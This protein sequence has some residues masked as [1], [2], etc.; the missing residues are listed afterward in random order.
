MKRMFR[1]NRRRLLG[2]LLAGACVVG[3]VLVS[4]AHTA[5]E[6]PGEHPLA[7]KYVPVFPAQRTMVKWEGKE[8]D[9]DSGIDVIMDAAHGPEKSDDQ[10]A[11]ALME[12]SQLRADLKGRPCLDVLAAR[13]DDASDLE[14]KVIL[15]CFTASGDPRGIP[16]FTNVLN[17]E[18]DLKLRVRAASGLASWNVRRGVAELVGLLDSDE[19]MPQ[20]SQLFYV[21][22]NAMRAFRLKNIRK[23]WGFP[24]DQES[25]EWPPDVAPPPDVAERLRPRPTV[26][27]IRKWWAENQHRFPD[28]KVGDPLP[29][30]SAEDATPE[31]NGDE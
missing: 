20:P 31:P 6:P 27:E 23:G 24:D 12:L 14:K 4:N 9:L 16:L 25:A 15:T 21:R 17:E 30:V 19:P 5:E 26:E 13:F 10:R 22:D 29:E 7:L 28:W 11:L 8:Y 2:K 3:V 18:K 1:K